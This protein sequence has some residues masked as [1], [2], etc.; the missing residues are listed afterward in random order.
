MNKEDLLFF[1]NDAVQI[2]LLNF[3]FSF[4]TVAILCF[5]I[6]LFYIKFSSTLSNRIQFSKIFGL[7]ICFV[8]VHVY[9]IFL[10]KFRFNNKK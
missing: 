9:G 1:A 6:Q 3:L 10:N 5:F 8:C 4:I 7:V 2:D